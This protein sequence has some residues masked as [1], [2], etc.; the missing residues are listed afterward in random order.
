MKSER[1]FFPLEYLSIPVFVTVFFLYGCGSSRAVIEE[2]DNRLQEQAKQIEQL[3]F[4]NAELQREIAQLSQGNRSLNAQVAELEKQLIEEG[5]RI[6]QPDV[7]MTTRPE[8]R[9][10]HTA[11]T[12]AAFENE[13]NR[14]IRLFRSRRYQDA[15]D[16]FTRLLHSGTDH[17]L[18]PN[19]QHWIGESLFGMREYNRAIEEFRKVFNYESK[20]KQDHAQVMIANSYFMLGNKD[21]A[22]QEYQRLIDRYPNSN[23]V[24]FA[25]QRLREI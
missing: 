4:D 25:R 12:P 11:I 7:T 15:R 24:S 3:Q 9:P 16:I 14:A 8:Q 6:R 21:R 1:S 13:Y 17:P 2:Q 20:Y 22:R 10:E 18:I 19:C 23:Y 5:E